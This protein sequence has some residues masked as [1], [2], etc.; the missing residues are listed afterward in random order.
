MS[1]F[2]TYIYC[3]IIFYMLYLYYK[4]G[5]NMS[6]YSKYHKAY[7]YKKMWMK[8]KTKMYAIGGEGAKEFIDKLYGDFNVWLKWKGIDL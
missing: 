5:T 1:N 3:Y 2:F 8:E 4:G 6:S 7:Y